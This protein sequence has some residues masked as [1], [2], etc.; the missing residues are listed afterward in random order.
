M[1][2]DATENKSILQQIQEMTVAQRLDLARRGGKEERTILMRDANKIIQVAV[3][4]SPKITESEVLSVAGNRQIN[5]EVLRIISA[6]REWMKNY[7]VKVA[8]VNNPKTPLPT[9]LKLVNLLG[10]KDL[11]QL[12]RS[13]SIPRAISVAAQGRLRVMKR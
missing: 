13:K 9:S 12:A 1:S 5:E 11:E 3:I 7:Q 8:L 4:Q 10:V 6:K 2:N